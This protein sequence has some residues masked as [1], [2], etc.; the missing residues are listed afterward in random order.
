[1]C[2]RSTPYHVG[3]SQKHYEVTRKHRVIGEVALLAV[4]IALVLNIA[5]YA[6]ARPAGILRNLAPVASVRAALIHEYV[7]ELDDEALVEAAIRGMVD[8]LGDKHTRYFDAEQLAS[9]NEEM[10]GSYSGI[11]AVI[12]LYENRLRIVQPFID[13]PA[14][15]AG[16]LPGD[17]V[18][19]IDGFDTEGISTEEAQHRLKGEAGTQVTVQ[20]RHADGEI[21]TFPITRGV[22]E[23]ATVRGYRQLDDGEQSY[24]IDPANGIAYIQL[25]QFGEKSLDEL[26]QVLTSLK[27]QGLNGLI[28][29]LRN[30]GGGLLTGAQGLSDLFLTGGQTIVTIRNRG[31]A[32]EILKSTDDTLLP[33]TPLVLLVNGQSA[34]ASEIVAG[35]LQDNGRA[36]IVGTRTYGKG[37]VQVFMPL[38]GS[39][40]ALKLTIAR[41]YVPSG[42]LIHRVPDAERWGVDPSPGSYVEMSIEEQLE[43]M[44]LSRDAMS[45]SPY[46]QLSGPVT[47]AWISEHLLD[48]QLAAAL[49]AAQTRA[50]SGDWP[51]LGGGDA[52]AEVRRSRRHLLERQRQQVTEALAEIDRELAE[53]TS[54]LS[55]EE[56]A[57][58]EQ[59]QAVPAQSDSEETVPQGV[60]QE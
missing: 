26:T 30:N 6:W 22:I 27:A 33:D 56:A 51:D 7:D 37:S 32:E 9:F 52:D 46:A 17:I 28:L 3:M 55:T 21:R 5:F 23:V 16:V 2:N 29:D 4:V 45:N 25:T 13:S 60:L 34:S 8:S 1:M 58:Q 41:W 48:T 54:G 59:P 50:D 18:L 39:P 12:D 10:Q 36:L 15:N 40:G 42:R 53:L 35:A 31:A 20:V 24:M 49:H 57:N 44:R 11:G 47:P 19:S 38:E 14:W 43:M